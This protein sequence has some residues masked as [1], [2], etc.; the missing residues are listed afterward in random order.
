MRDVMRTGTPKWRARQVTVSPGP[1]T[2]DVT[3]ATARSP[4]RRIDAVCAST[5]RLSAKHA[6]GAAGISVVSTIVGTGRS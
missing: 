3:P 6:S 4:E 1:M 5:D 2:P